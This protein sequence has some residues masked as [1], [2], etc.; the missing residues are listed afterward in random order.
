MCHSVKPAV[1]LVWGK[2]FLSRSCV[3]RTNAATR[4]SASCIR[5]LSRGTRRSDR[6]LCSRESQIDVRASLRCDGNNS[7]KPQCAEFADSPTRVVLSVSRF[8]TGSPSE[9]RISSAIN[10]DQM[11][12]KICSDRFTSR[13]QRPRVHAC[14]SLRHGLASHRACSFPQFPYASLKISR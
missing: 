2:R 4:S 5:S 14:R 10:F 8:G 12:V 6:N 11:R 1:F 3:G 7:L 9:K 13:R